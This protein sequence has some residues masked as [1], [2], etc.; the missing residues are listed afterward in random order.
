MKREGPAPKLRTLCPPGPRQGTV[1]NDND[2][3]CHWRRRTLL[4]ST[5]FVKDAQIRNSV[6]P[7]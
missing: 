1:E 5:Q 2:L 4:K 3:Q 6:V 7:T